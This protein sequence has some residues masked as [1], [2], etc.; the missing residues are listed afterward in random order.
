MFCLQRINQ[1]IGSKMSLQ[2]KEMYIT[3]VDA[4]FPLNTAFVNSI[5][6]IPFI[7]ADMSIIVKIPGKAAWL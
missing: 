3:Y 4:G 6:L 1:L 2:Q 7:K 5:Y